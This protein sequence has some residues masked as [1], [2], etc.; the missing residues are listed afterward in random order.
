MRASTPR[1]LLTVLV[2]ALLLAPEALLLHRCACGRIFD[3]CCRKQVKQAA[4][5][6]SCPLHAG[7]AG[8]ACC[9]SGS[10]PASVQNR[11]EP[12]DRLGTSLSPR[13]EIRLALAGWTSEVRRDVFSG[14]S[15]EPLVPPPR[16]ALAV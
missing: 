16:L 1:T 9:S 4:A 11:Q 7:M 6:E 3:C 2:L 8:M 10:L 12:V 13:L 15:P 5:G 14:P